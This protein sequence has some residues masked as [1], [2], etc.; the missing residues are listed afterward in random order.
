MT[1][2]QGIFS[3]DIG[4]TGTNAF[5]ADI[6]ANTSTLYLEIIVDGVTLSPR[7]QLTA[8]PFALNATYLD[9]YAP[10]VTGTSA[11]IPLSDS[12]GNFTFA[13]DPQSSAVSGGVVYIN[14]LT[15]G[16]DETLLGIGVGG[17]QRFRVDEDGDTFVTGGIFASSTLEV[18]Q[19]ST[20]EGFVNIRGRFGNP[21]I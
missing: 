4:A 1:P 9:G 8:A 12:N 13:G 5:G 20:F 10:A 17:S 19:T 14:P 18:T 2:V 16:A 3:V 11:Y 21:E 7:K 6:F 15:A